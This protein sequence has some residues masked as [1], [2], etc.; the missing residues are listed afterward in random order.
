[1]TQM[2]YPIEDREL[3]YGLA[4]EKVLYKNDP[5]KL[6]YYTIPE[7]IPSFIGE[8]HSKREECML[9]MNAR[10]FTLYHVSY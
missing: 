1:M 4:L 7:Y 3:I 9:E 5:E 8:S 10:T 6:D 2:I